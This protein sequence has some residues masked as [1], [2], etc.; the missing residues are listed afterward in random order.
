MP[1]QGHYTITNESLSHLTRKL[2]SKA[3]CEFFLYFIDQPPKMPGKN[4]FFALK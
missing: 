3:A 1:V 2:L 4:T